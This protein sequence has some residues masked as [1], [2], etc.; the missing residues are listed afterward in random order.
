MDALM[1][2][3]NHDT[4]TLT[5]SHSH[6]HTHTHPRRHPNQPHSRA[7]AHS[8]S[9]SL[10]HS[11]ARSLTHSLTQARQMHS[12]VHTD[13]RTHSQSWCRCGRGEPRCRCGRGEPM[14]CRCASAGCASFIE[15]GPRAS[16]PGDR[17]AR[18]QGATQ[19]VATQRATLQRS[20]PRRPLSAS[21]TASI[22][23]ETGLIPPTPAPGL[24]SPC[25]YLHRDWAHPANTC[26]GR[27]SFRPHPGRDWP[28]RYPLCSGDTGARRCSTKCRW[29]S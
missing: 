22:C 6:S 26:T 10:A 27:G 4:H 1:K 18:C 17:L 29:P 12:R 11:V 23:A 24:G 9:H 7:R 13:T 28:H 25:P 15:L 3:P 5:H 16:Q 21:A 2:P 20:S 14:P 8:L 19:C